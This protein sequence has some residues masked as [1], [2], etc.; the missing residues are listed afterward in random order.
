MLSDTHPDAEQVQIELLQRMTPAERLGKTL[1]FTSALIDSS[2]Q[3]IAAMNPGLNSQELD[4]KCV[5]LYYGEALATQLREY[6]Q[7]RTE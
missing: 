7:A 4:V 3:T 1:S 6:L 5:E 2:R